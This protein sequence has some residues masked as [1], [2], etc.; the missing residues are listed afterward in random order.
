MESSL[1]CFDVTLNRFAGGTVPTGTESRYGKCKGREERPKAIDPGVG[2]PA[3]G[4]AVGRRPRPGSP[5]IRRGREAGRH[6][7]SG[8]PLVS[9]RKAS[10]T[11]PTRN[12]TLM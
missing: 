7:G 3:A 4:G 11:S 5:V 12:T 8:R 9:G 6:S 1:W 2:G 10:A